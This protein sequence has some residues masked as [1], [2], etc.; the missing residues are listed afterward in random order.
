MVTDPTVAPG[1]QLPD[2]IVNR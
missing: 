1:R 2:G